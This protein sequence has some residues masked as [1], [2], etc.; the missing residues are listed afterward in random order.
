MATLRITRDKGYADLVRTYIVMVDGKKIGELRN[1]ESKE[2]AISPG[3]HSITAKID[4]CS[5]KTLRFHVKDGD[6]LSFDICSNLRGLKI[7]L[8]L[9][10]ALFERDSYL[11]IEESDR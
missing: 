2:F 7:L 3:D 11:Q 6:T 8:V 9:W 10:Y 1:G 4:W 5:S